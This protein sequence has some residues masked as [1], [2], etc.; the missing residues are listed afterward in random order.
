MSKDVKD[1]QDGCHTCQ[2]SKRLLCNSTLN[3]CA[4]RKWE[5]ILIDIIVG[6]PTTAVGYNSILTVTDKLS[7]R[8]HL[9]PSSIEWIGGAEV[10]RLSFDNTWKLHGAP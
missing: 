8:V 2:M 7:K 9:I 4:I 10:A 6:L 3:S 5:T 1:R